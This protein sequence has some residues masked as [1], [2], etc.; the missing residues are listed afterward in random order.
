[1]NVPRA[2]AALSRAFFL[3]CVWACG[4]SESQEDPDVVPP[5]FQGLASAMAISST[6]VVLQ[7]SAAEDDRSA[8]TDIVYDICVSTETGSCVAVFVLVQSSQPGEL[9]SAV[10]SLAP[11]TTYYFAARSRDQ[12]GNSDSNMT[13]LSATT[14]GPGVYQGVVVGPGHTCALMHNG[15]VACWGAPLGHDA[16]FEPFDATDGFCLDAPVFPERYSPCTSSP[17]LLTKP[18][19]VV[20]LTIG[21]EH[22][23]ALLRTGR[24]MCWGASTHGQ[25][26][27]SPPP[28]CTW[29]I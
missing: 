23:C 28:R 16:G 15:K 10:G 9:V 11:M 3:I 25:T 5:S 18:L 7:W 2:V 4:P 17:K 6:T 8:Q 21:W 13:E 1:M 14:I 26:G 22:V 12:A 27:T 19:D 29:S 24:V 20:Q